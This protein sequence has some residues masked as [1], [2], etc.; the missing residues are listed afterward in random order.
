MSEKYIQKCLKPN[1]KLKICFNIDGIPLF[2]SNKS[3]LWPILGLVKNF[4]S[5]PFVTSI[6]CGIS[7]PKPLNVFLSNFINELNDLLKNRF[8]LNGNHFKIKI[9]SFVCD[10]PARAYLKCTKTHSGYSSSEP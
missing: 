2:K 7:K 8:N 5:V 4:R 1:K 10:A 3:Q 9:H 6:F